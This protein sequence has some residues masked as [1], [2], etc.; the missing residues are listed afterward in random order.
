M[1]K[2]DQTIQEIEKKKF[3]REKSF[4]SVYFSLITTLTYFQYIYFSKD[5][6][7]AHRKIFQI[8]TIHIHKIIFYEN[9]V[10]L[11]SDWAS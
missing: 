4:Y 5:Q 9:W 1:R 2:H 3:S 10:G 6:A 11:V 7:Q 8:Q